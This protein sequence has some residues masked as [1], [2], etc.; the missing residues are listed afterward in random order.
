[1][2]YNSSPCNILHR[3]LLVS[4]LLIAFASF[5]ISARIA[6]SKAFIIT[7]YGAEGNGQTLNTI[8]IQKAIDACAA[9]GGGV[10]VVP[11]GVFVSGAIFLKKKVNL[12]IEK[13]AVLKG[14]INQA[15]YPQINTRWEGTEM[16]FTAALVNGDSLK[17]VKI[18]GEGMIDGSGDA[19]L[20]SRQTRD[21][22]RGAV[23]L[24][25]PRLM[26]FQNSKGVRVSGLKL[27]N[28][29]V[30]CVFILYCEDVVLED[31][32]IRA[33]H[34]IPSSDGIDIDSSKKVK[35]R[36]CDIDVN[37]DCISIGTN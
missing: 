30:W 11:K 31:L 9:Q 17:N 2:I 26:G 18:Y 12:M 1:M 28:Q 19:W 37:D 27:H 15:D 29:A 36:R 13:D 14:S 16:K 35:I 7:A 21:T 24:G 3:R 22:T 25:R 8:A 34:N 4:L 10:V 33:N 23:R 20:Q 5:F 6:R 32:H